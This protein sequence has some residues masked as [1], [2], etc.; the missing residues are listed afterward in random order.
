LELGVDIRQD[1]VEIGLQP[2]F[3]ESTRRPLAFECKQALKFDQD[4]GLT[5]VEN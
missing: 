3:D 5:G 2:R 1:K 4:P